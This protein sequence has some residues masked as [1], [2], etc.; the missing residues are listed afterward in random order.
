VSAKDEELHDLDVDE[1]EEAEEDDDAEAVVA[2]D[3]DEPSDDASLEELL[4]QRSAARRAPDELD[5][6]D[7]IMALA[8]ERHVPLNEPLP[9]R[10]IPIKDRDEFVCNRCHLVKK[11]SQLAD[12]E[13]GLCRDCV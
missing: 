9:T 12:E 4:A 13:R 2:D 6:E 5:D 8:S 11:R 7:D 10:V 1:P 3:E